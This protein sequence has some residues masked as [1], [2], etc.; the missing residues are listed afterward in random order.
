M[1]Q[2]KYTHI[3]T[4]MYGDKEE[5]TPDLLT[6]VVQKTE[7]ADSF[8][9]LRPGVRSFVVESPTNVEVERNARIEEIKR[10]LLEEERKRQ[11]ARS[12][13]LYPP[14]YFSQSASY[15]PIVDNPKTLQMEPKMIERKPEPEKICPICHDPTCQYW[16]AVK[17]A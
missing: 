12:Y 9:N 13:T 2:R 15:A 3:Y 16:E 5:Q 14:V 4:L 10:K 6:Q 7:Q 17:N 1:E 8:S 11:L